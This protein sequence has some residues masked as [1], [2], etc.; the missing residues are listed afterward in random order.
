MN[1]S[2]NATK[3]LIHTILKWGLICINQPV[4]ADGLLFPFR[5]N[6]HN[7]GNSN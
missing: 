1:E 3:Y 4:L 7:I 5:T 2:L 6:I